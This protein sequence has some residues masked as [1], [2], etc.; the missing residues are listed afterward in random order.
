MAP[1][2]GGRTPFARLP[3]ECTVGCLAILK[4]ADLR[5]VA[6]CCKAWRALRAS[7]PFIA[8]RKVVDERALVLAGWETK[9]LNHD[10]RCFVLQ[11]F[12]H[13]RK[14]REN[15]AKFP[16][17]GDAFMIDRLKTVIFQGKLF[18]VLDACD[19]SNDYK[20]IQKWYEYDLAVRRWVEAKFPNTGD[21]ADSICASTTVVVMLQLPENETQSISLT[22]SRPGDDAWVSLP[23]P[24]ID[25]YHGDGCFEPRIF[26][27]DDVLYLVGGQQKPEFVLTRAVQALDLSNNTWTLCAPMPVPRANASIVEVGGRIYVLGGS[28]YAAGSPLAAI[29]EGVLDGAPYYETSNTMVSYDP[30]TDRWAAEAPLP[31]PASRENLIYMSAVAHEGSIYVV[32]KANFRLGGLFLREQGGTDYEWLPC[33]PRTPYDSDDSEH[34]AGRTYRASNANLASLPLW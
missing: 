19:T 23:N 7:A 1:S 2:P 28:V 31:L 25:L 18:A 27:L 26:C 29:E 32:K 3:P 12:G 4:F 10:T 17:L 22:C 15:M 6:S 24:P 34:E 16:T 30:L 14:W 13:S 21:W 5:A 20:P 33:V 11:R 8:A 9:E